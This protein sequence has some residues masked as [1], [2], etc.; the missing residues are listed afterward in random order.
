MTPEQRAERDRLKTTPDKVEADNLRLRQENEELSRR[1]K[2]ARIALQ[3][4]A[5]EATSELNRKKEP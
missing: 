2:C 5:N 4:I 1:L 3:C